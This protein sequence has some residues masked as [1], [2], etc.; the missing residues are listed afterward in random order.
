MKE[1][2]SRL[3]VTLSYVDIIKYESKNFILFFQK[4][5]EDENSHEQTDEVLFN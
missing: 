3:R 5:N 1:T 2:A 4:R